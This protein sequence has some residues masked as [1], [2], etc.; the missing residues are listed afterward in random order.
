M[1]LKELNHFFTEFSYDFS[2][3]KQTVELKQKSGQITFK[4]KI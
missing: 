4:S 3:E 2:L 1:F